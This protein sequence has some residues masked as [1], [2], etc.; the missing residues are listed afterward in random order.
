MN[1]QEYLKS[2]ERLGLSPAGKTLAHIL[3]LSVRHCQRIADGEV[4]VPIG[5]AR[6]LRAL[7]YIVKETKE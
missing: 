2:L 1:T 7:M 5:S 6:L 4:I 3:G